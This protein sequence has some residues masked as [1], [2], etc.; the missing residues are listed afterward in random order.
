MLVLACACTASQPTFVEDSRLTVRLPSPSQLEESL[1][2]LEVRAVAAAS[3][4]DALPVS[5]RRDKAAGRRTYL[6][7]TGAPVRA[8]LDL[9]LYRSESSQGAIDFWRRSDP[10]EAYMGE[11][12]NLVD[13]KAEAIQAQQTLWRFVLESSEM[14]ESATGLCLVGWNARGLDGCSQASWWTAFCTWTLDV[15]LSMPV[16][17]DVEPDMQPDLILERVTELM[18]DEL[19]CV[20]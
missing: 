14:P 8:Q 18:R 20:A 1:R 5:P 12:L 15:V 9:V 6:I 2:D 4:S 3:S 7:T 16:G 19:G 11:V 10:L 13:R 17:N